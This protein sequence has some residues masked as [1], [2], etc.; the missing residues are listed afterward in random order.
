MWCDLRWPQWFQLLD[1]LSPC[2]QHRPLKAERPFCVLL[3]AST[4]K[5]T[6]K[7][8]K[9]ERGRERG[10]RTSM[11]AQFSRFTFCA[12]TKHCRASPPHLSLPLLPVSQLI[13]LLDFLSSCSKFFQHRA[14]A[15]GNHN[16]TAALLLF[17]SRTGF[18]TELKIENGIAEAL[19]RRQIFAGRHDGA[20]TKDRLISW[21]ALLSWH[22]EGRWYQT[23]CI[24]I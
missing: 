2:L 12:F 14:A 7:E 23:A 17:K 3:L 1:F 19:T 24:T 11:T 16:K 18:Y 10:R 6:K 21:Q 20:H 9:M 15:L 5:V 13:S 8:K 4:H 22:D